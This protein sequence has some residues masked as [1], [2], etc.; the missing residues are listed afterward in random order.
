MLRR[1]AEVP[2]TRGEILRFGLV[3]LLAAGL[4]FGLLVGLVSLGVSPYAARIGSVGVAMVFTWLLNRN[5]TFAAAAPPSWREFASYAV[6]SMLGMAINFT[7]YSAAVYFGAPLWL[8][9]CAGV[10]VA[11]VFNFLRYRVLF[12][13]ER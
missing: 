10:G 6:T 4:D 11:M 7:V 3:G 13:R 9:F 12:A 8:A 1:L 2:G 5:L